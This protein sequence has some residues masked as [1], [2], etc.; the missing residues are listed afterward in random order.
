MGINHKLIVIYNL[1]LSALVSHESAALVD[2]AEW[3]EPLGVL[4]VA[5]RTSGSSAYALSCFAALCSG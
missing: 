1:N 4:R 5:A 2:H 3:P